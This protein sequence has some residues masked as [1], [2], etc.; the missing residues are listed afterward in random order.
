MYLERGGEKMKGVIYLRPETIMQRAYLWWRFYMHSPPGV[1]FESVIH[2]MLSHGVYELDLEWARS[3]RLDYMLAQKIWS[4]RTRGNRRDISLNQVRGVVFTRESMGG[5]NQPIQDDYI[6]RDVSDPLDR[7]EPY[8]A[9]LEAQG[10]DRD[11]T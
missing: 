11:T 3:R 5:A 6:Y 2:S 4:M 7:L 8:F 1:L 10:R 9:N